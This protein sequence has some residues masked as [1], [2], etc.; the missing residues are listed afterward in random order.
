M[1]AICPILDAQYFNPQGEPLA[2]GKLWFYAG[3]SFSIDKVTYANNSGTIVNPNPIVL[4]SSGYLPVNVFLDTG[5]YNVA[6]TEADGTTVLETWVNIEGINCDCSQYYIGAHWPN[7]TFGTTYFD[8]DIDSVGNIYSVGRFTDSVGSITSYGLVTKTS[9]SGELLWQR[10]ASVNHPLGAAF[11]RCVVDSEDN[12]YVAGLRSDQDNVFPPQN[13][14]IVV[15]KYTSTGTLAWQRVLTTGIPGQEEAFELPIG[16]TIDDDDNVY[17]GF[18]AFYGYPTIVKYNKFGAL[19]WNKQVT[20]SSNLWI[21]N[22]SYDSDTNEICYAGG[23]SPGGLGRVGASD[24]SYQW[25]TGI[26]VVQDA[27]LCGT[28]CRNGDTWVLMSTPGAEV[29]VLT[30]F[31]IDSTQSIEWQRQYNMPTGIITNYTWELSLVDDELFVCTN[32][33]PVSTQNQIDVLRVNPNTGSYISGWSILYD[34]SS[35][36]AY[37]MSVRDNTIALAGFLPRIAPSNVGLVARLPINNDYTGNYGWWDYNTLSV[38]VTTP[39]YTL[40]ALS[41]ST[42]PGTLIDQTGNLVAY[43]QRVTADLAVL[44]PV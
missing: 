39:A 6:L 20:Y 10:Y 2:G 29:Y 7:R 13:Y 25:S 9:D 24:G 34:Q 38:S 27:F 5:L 42:I 16:F 11:V 23:G 1:P 32:T 12:V 40:M 18:G 14:D 3:G 41:H 36:A 33:N 37:G 21:R 43:T 35:I 44:I 31:K 28:V 26:A 22:L 19:Q 30:L 17:I 15:A 4:D 8:C